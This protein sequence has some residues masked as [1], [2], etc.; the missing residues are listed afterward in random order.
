MTTKRSQWVKILTGVLGF[1]L[2][3]G[4][5]THAQQ[6]QRTGGSANITSRPY[7]PNGTIGDAVISAD[8]DTKQITV[9]ADEATARYVRQVIKGLD[10]PKPQVLIKVVFLEVSYNNA[11]DIGF[12]G[13]ITRK[14]SGSMT[15]MASNVFGAGFLGTVPPGAGLYTILGNDFQATLRLIAQA[16]KAEILSRPSILTRNNQQATISIGQQVPLITGTR[17]DTQNNQIN[18]FSYQ[19]VGVNLQVTP[20]ITPDGMVE[21]IVTP[22]ISQLADKSQWVPT[23]SGPAGIVLSPVINSRSADTVVVVPDAQT[24]VIGGLMENNKV[25]S[26]SKIPILGDIPLIGNL[27][28]RQIKNY[29]KTELIIFLTPHIVNAPEQ[30]AALSAGERANSKLMPKAFTE[31]E[32][33]RFL[34]TVPVKGAAAPTGNASKNKTANSQPSKGQK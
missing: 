21:L 12:E 25:S 4:L 1:C 31:E 16:G 6:G 30:L 13:S 27:F 19:K 15:G 23:S 5:E 14:L 2:C 8:T 17:I 10:Q 29:T 9:I 28:K 26:E 18:T 33:D 20:F 3:A 11:S 22:E 34:D 32:L 7:V 24:V